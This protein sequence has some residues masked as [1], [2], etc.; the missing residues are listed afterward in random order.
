[1]SEAPPHSASVPPARSTPPPGA[2]ARA[3]LRRPWGPGRVGVA[4][5]AL[6]FTVSVEAGVVS[7]FDSDLKSLAARLT[8]Q[9]MLAVTLVG[10]AFVA[11]APDG[12]TSAPSALGLRRPS[13][14]FVKTAA[15]AYVAYI[16]FALVYSPLVQPHQEDVTRDLGFGQSALGAIAAGILIVAAAPVSEEIFF[17]GFLFG[18]LRSRLPFA[19]AGPIS[20]GIFGLFH[21]TGA[22]SWGVLPQLAVLGLVLAFVYERTGSI[23]P[24]ICV[25]ALNNALA[26]ALLAS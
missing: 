8:L 22:G 15:L 2:E 18:G 16:A 14:S 26:F 5:V 7:A 3:E 20:A 6:L 19:V 11:S 9:A 13:G 23:L 12:G 21:Y 24:T 4:I 17:R 25:H 10:I 1:M